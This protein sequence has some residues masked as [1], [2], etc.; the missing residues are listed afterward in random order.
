MNFL[1]VL[2]SIFCA[3]ELKQIP[4][5]VPAISSIKHVLPMKMA[6]TRMTIPKIERADSFPK[7]CSAQPPTQK[8]RR[9]YVHAARRYSDGATSCELATQGYWESGFNISAIS[10]VGAIGISQ[11][12]PSTAKEHG[13]DPYDP[14]SSIFGQAR[15]VRWCRLRWPKDHGRTDKDIRALGLSCYNWGI[16]NMRR[17]QSRNGWILYREARP[18]LPREDS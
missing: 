18:Y 3:G 16:G 6:R 14:R 1:C 2:L 7:G 13:V 4:V 9:H 12:L 10:P 8:L 17:D 15:Y 5:H 11:F